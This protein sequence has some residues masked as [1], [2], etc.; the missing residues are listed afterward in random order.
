M[1]KPLAAVSRRDDLYRDI[2]RTNLARAVVDLARVGW[3]S[4]KAWPMLANSGEGR[5]WTT[6]AAAA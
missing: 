2:A 5:G 3:R 4:I 6:G 1:V